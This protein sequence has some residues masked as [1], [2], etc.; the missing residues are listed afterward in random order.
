MYE[1]QCTMHIM[2]VLQIYVGPYDLCTICGVPVGLL[3]TDQS[4]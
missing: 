1:Q 3:A 4:T 2:N